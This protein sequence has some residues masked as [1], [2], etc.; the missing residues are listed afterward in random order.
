MIWNLRNP[1]TQPSCSH[2]P[3]K[4]LGNYFLKMPGRSTASQ[5]QSGDTGWQGTGPECQ[6]IA[7]HPLRSHLLQ[8][9]LF[10][11]EEEATGLPTP[12]SYSLS[13][14][15]TPTFLPLTPAGTTGQVW[16]ANKT[17]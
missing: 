9:L 15:P 4:Q 16:A 8:S 3:A 10:Q 5:E 17:D 2:Q 1:K 11:G 14:L 13:T 12:E 7:A 6:D